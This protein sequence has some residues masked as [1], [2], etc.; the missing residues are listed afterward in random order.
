M[1]PFEP[2]PL[3]NVCGTLLAGLPT[4]GGMCRS[5]P[6]CL[7]PQRQESRPQRAACLQQQQPASRLQTAA[8]CSHSASPGCHFTGAGHSL[9]AARPRR[10]CCCLPCRSRLL[11]CSGGGA[12][13]Q[14]PSRQCRPSLSGRAVCDASVFILCGYHSDLR[15]GAASLPSSLPVHQQSTRLLSMCALLQNICCRLGAEEMLT[16][17]ALSCCRPLSLSSCVL[18]P[19]Q[20]AAVRDLLMGLRANETK[21][22]ACIGRSRQ[23][24][25]RGGTGGG[26]AVW[27]GAWDAHG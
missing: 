14:G 18:L 26:A 27:E 2:A 5:S 25:G 15:Q 6:L 10:C 19:A 8:P 3:L 13:G 9:V 21:R 16:L 22:G 11:R 7:H 23:S 12:D 1:Q 20:P 4:S 24:G 17:R